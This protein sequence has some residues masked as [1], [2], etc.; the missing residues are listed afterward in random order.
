MAKKYENMTDAEKM[1]YFICTNHKGKMENMW[2][3]ST[4]TLLNKNCQRMREIEGSICQSCYAYAMA[5]YR[6]SMAE[7]LRRATEFLTTRIVPLK[8]IPYLNC[9]LFRFEAFGD[10]N[11]EKQVVNYFNYA[12]KNGHVHCA[13]WTKH[14]QVIKRAMEVYGIEKPKNLCI[15]LSS[16]MLNRRLNYE[17]VIKVYPFVDKIF[18]VW[19]K[20]EA[21]KQG[22]IINCGGRKCAI[23][24]TCYH[25]E[26]GIVYIDELKK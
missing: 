24:Q 15:I 6:K 20:E 10:I 2:S 14:P 23:C 8:D 17:M 25:I 22:I 3:I 21:E 12:R 4:S 16:P 1:M 11:N 5:M 19:T 26:N 9:E 13:L 7:K 18:T